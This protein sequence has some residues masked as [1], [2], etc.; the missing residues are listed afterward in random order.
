MDALARI[1]EEIV[2]WLNQWAGRWGVLTEVER[3]LVSDYFIP[4]L[5]GLCL[6]AAWFLGGDHHTRDLRQ[7]AVLRALL[8][9]GFASLAVLILNELYFRPRP[10]VDHD[11]SLLF[12]Q[13]TDSSF[14]AH[15]SAVAFGMASSMWQGSRRL[16]AFICVLAVLWGLSRVSAGVAYPSDVAAGGLIGIV[17]SYVVALALRLIE[18]IPTVVLRATRILHLA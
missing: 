17:V 5:A 9:V 8:T 6:M 4:A 13:P 1:D 14:P 12:Y 16:G 11:L 18:P 7:R 10:F 2:L 15:P 3:L